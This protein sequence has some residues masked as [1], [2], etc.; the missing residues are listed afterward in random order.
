MPGDVVLRTLGSVQRRTLS[1]VTFGI[2]VV[3][4]SSAGERLGYM[5]LWKCTSCV[6]TLYSR[7]NGV[8]PIPYLVNMS[9]LISEC[10]RVCASRPRGLRV[11]T[12]C[13]PANA[14]S[15]LYVHVCTPC[16]G[17]AEFASLYVK[18]Y[19]LLPLAHLGLV[20]QRSHDHREHLMF[21]CVASD[22]SKSQMTV[23]H[24]GNKSM[25]H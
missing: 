10:A 11:R 20:C 14:N 4:H 13:D 7:L 21:L 9:H 18:V 8:H 12:R 22:G 19:L 15:I 3:T 23:R 6:I 17:N 5:V 2:W 16:H 25:K 1:K 24:R